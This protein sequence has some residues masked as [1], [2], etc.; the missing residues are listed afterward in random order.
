M[1]DGGADIAGSTARQQ[2]AR[3]RARLK[4]V[5]S[6]SARFRERYAIVLAQL[7]A[8]SLPG[9]TETAI[10]AAQTNPHHAGQILSRTVRSA[11]SGEHPDCNVQV[12]GAGLAAG[13]LRDFFAGCRNVDELMYRHPPLAQ[14]NV[15]LHPSRQARLVRIPGFP[16]EFVALRWTAGSVVSRVDNQRWMTEVIKAMP[17]GRLRFKAQVD[18]A[19]ARAEPEADPWVFSP[20]LGRTLEDTLRSG[21]LAPR[22][23]RDVV[24]SL[25]ALRAAMLRSGRIW[26][27][28]APRNMFLRGGT[29]HL[30]DFEETAD[31]Q[32]APARAAECLLWHR[33]FFADCLEPAEKEILFGADSGAV[34]VDDAHV[35]EADSFE[36]ALLDTATVQWGQRRDLLGESERLEGRHRR[37]GPERHGGYLHGHEL[38]HF[39][40]DFLT[41]AT[42]ARLFRRLEPVT[43]ETALV[44]CLEVFEAAMEADICDRIYEEMTGRPLGAETR[45]TTAMIDVLEA[46][47]P[48]ELAAFRSATKDW[49]DRLAY[50]PAELADAVLLAVGKRAGGV[51]QVLLDQYLVGGTEAR[52]RHEDSLAQT[53]RAGLDF[54]HRADSGRSF[55]RYEEPHSLQAII[56]RSLPR[57]GQDFRDVLSEVEELAAGYS[58]SQSH[59][60]Y[61]AF[62]DSGNAVAALA[63]NFFATLL[64]QNLI[65]VD[66]S[67]PAATFIEIQVIEWLRELVGYKVTPLSEMRGLKDVAGLWTTGGHLSNHVAMLAAL[68][69]A[70]PLAR[71]RGLRSLDKQPAIVMAGPIAHYSHSDAAFHLGL[72]WD[73][74]IT[75]AANTDYTT[76]VA[77]VERALAN[78]PAGLAPF[79]VVGV[80]GNSR[81]TGLD[82]LAGLGAV[83]RRHGVWFHVDACHGGSLIFSERLRRRIAGIDAADSVSL[84]PHKG[85]FTPYPSS[86]LLLRE[87][88]VL[89]Q[90]SRHETAVLDD[91][92]WDLGLITPFI[93]SRGFHSLATW[94][95][96][97]HAGADTLGAIVESRFALI[98]YLEGRLASSRLFVLLNDVDFYR[99]TFVF[100]P[101]SARAAMARLPTADRQRAVGIIS[102]YTSRLNT[103]LYQGGEACFDEHTLTDLDNRV[104]A[105]A[106]LRYTVIAACPGNPLTSQTE[107][108]EAIGCLVERATAMVEPLL[109]EIHQSGPDS[110]GDHSM[111]TAGPAGWDDVR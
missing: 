54:I 85:L 41:A 21:T 64:N 20:N 83:C 66:R 90:F 3:W 109:A 53:V 100:C 70:F 68:G 34:C 63:G 10:T 23:R 62:P 1:T 95:L 69:R 84:D 13:S 27:G 57:Q 65:A 5:P 102:A 38:G 103:A 51:D 104:G 111:R 24:S 97:R 110:T 33:V 46:T 59:P 93:G 18:Y 105:G 28:F 75:V 88:G 9:D 71:R 40:G 17:S 77:A 80:A 44:A 16:G 67:G 91:D 76:D 55:L 11:V 30:I 36:R 96:L 73:N 32:L 47:G 86:Y 8:V 37:P 7:E 56:G 78:P 42:E 35:L 108:D 49:Y 31:L 61:L 74:V 72:G 25:Q 19:L 89:T 92:C 98:R 81:T 50:D 106:D 2:V 52:T 45:R 79:M 48:G 12:E 101:P 14:T 107:L 58:V 82:D 15:P 22:D 60:R 6:L 94:M 26:Q 29:I 99:L 43:Q 87:R 4:D 39:W